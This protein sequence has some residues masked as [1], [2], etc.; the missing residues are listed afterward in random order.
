MP[1]IVKYVTYVLANSDFCTYTGHKC[2]FLHKK[3]AFSRFNHRFAVEN[4][5]TLNRYVSLR[6]RNASRIVGIPQ[7]VKPPKANHKQ[8][9]ANH[10][11]RARWHICP[12]L[13]ML[14][15]PPPDQLL[16]GFGPGNDHSFSYI[17]CKQKSAMAGGKRR[18]CCLSQKY[19]MLIYII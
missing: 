4:I 10:S 11:K 15:N 5:N 6:D 16:Q 12:N 8:R 18:K 14:L 17:H 2:L 13:C 19:K 9:S 3:G 1:R 7:A